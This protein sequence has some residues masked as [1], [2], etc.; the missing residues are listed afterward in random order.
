MYNAKNLYAPLIATV[1]VGE[2]PV[3]VAKEAMKRSM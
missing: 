1:H 3:E 2:K